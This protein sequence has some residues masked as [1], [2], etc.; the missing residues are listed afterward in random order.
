MR[1]LFKQRLFSWFDTYDIY[2]EANETVFT[3]QGKMSWGHKLEVRDRSG[4]A[5]GM[6]EEKIFRFLPTF[7][8]YERG[9]Y[10][11]CI[12]KEFSF[13]KP[14]FTIDMNGWQ[15]NGDWWEWD[16]TIVDNLGLTVAT[17]SKR[18]GWTDT[19]VLDVYNDSDALAVLMVVLA[20]DAE[21]C[22]R[23]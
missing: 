6:L 20:I 12:K 17:I 10:V 23:N 5:I 18:M 1:L 8:I 14:T 13:F 4:R 11:G 21:K 15:I 22:S 2:N 16:Y 19:Y 3:V 7:E 9:N